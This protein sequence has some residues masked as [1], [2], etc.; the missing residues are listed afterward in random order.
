MTTPIYKKTYL[1]ITFFVFAL[2]LFSVLQNQAVAADTQFFP[3]DGCK[4]DKVM[5]ITMKDG[6]ERTVCMLPEEFIRQ[7]MIEMNCVDKVLTF[8]AAGKLVCK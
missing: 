4:E 8:D 3:P 7:A 6:A 1:K 5:I 2:L